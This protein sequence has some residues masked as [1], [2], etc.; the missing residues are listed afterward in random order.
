VL[1]EVACVARALEELGHRVERVAVTLDLE[2]MLRL[3]A[4]LKPDFVFNLVESLAG[5]DSL[6]HLA[7]AALESAGH[8]FSGSSADSIYLTTNKD[9]TKRLLRQAGIPTPPWQSAESVLQSGP[10]F[11]PPYF[12]K[13]LA[14][15][16]SRG[17]DDSSVV[18]SRE[19]LL[20]VLNAVPPGGRAGLMVE[21]YVE[22]REFNVSILAGPGGP[23]VLPPAEMQFIDYPPGK[24][25]I[26][27][28]SAKWDAASFEYEH[29]VRRFDLPDSDK[30]LLAELDRLSLRTWDALGLSGYARVDFRV[31]RRGK[32]FVLEAN[33]NPCIAPDA[34]FVAAT[35]RAG[36]SYRDMIQRVISYRSGPPSCP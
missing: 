26:V 14:E 6:Q 30:P 2:S 4:E 36:M 25:A 12:V 8:S 31:S 35:T 32:P 13:R 3:L 22:G 15:D 5:S 7:P 34:G 10:S 21:A 33:A 29:T 1:V 11:G 28:Y 18:M 17:I 20:A 19:K 24:P 16:A 27:G 23:E 9:I